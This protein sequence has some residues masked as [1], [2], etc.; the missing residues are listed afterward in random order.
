VPSV[1]VDIE[2]AISLRGSSGVQVLINGKPSILTDDGG[3]LGSITADMIDSIEVIT[4]PSAKYDAEGTSGIINI[5]I[6]KDERKGINGALSL[7]T[8]I[9]DNNSVGISLN[10]RSEKFNLFT[11]MEIQKIPMKI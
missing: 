7:N 11:Q 6:K 3:A 8:G 4:N 9:P 5:V 2:G 1:N 10:R